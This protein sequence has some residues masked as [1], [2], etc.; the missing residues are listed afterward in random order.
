MTK[1]DF[2]I[3]YSNSIIWIEV[4]SSNAPVGSSHK[5]ILGSLINALAI[6]ILCFWP[7]DKLFTLSFFLIFKSTISKTSST[8]LSNFL[9][10]LFDIDSNG[11]RIF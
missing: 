3:L 4:F 2:D 8:L 7:P 6:A 5:I 10:E 9:F 1:L 11:S